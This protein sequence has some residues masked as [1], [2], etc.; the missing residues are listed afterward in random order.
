MTANNANQEQPQAAGNAHPT[1]AAKK[2]MAV[3]GSIATILGVVVAL[4]TIWQYCS[5]P[6][7]V[8]NNIVL[9]VDSSTAMQEPMNEE[10][11]RL[12]AARSAFEQVIYT[13]SDQDNLALR[14]F[15]GACK[16]EDNTRMLVD[17]GQG[18][19]QRIADAVGAIQPRGQPTVIRG[20]AEAIG[21]F[22]DAAR[23][24]GT[25]KRIVAL[26]GGC[27]P[28]IAGF[29][30]QLNDTLAYRSD[31]A[32]RYHL[33]GLKLDEAC[34]RQLEQLDNIQLF[35]AVSQAQVTAAMKNA[36]A[37]EPFPQVAPVITTDL[38]DNRITV[39]EETSVKIIVQ[40]EDANG[41][42]VNLRVDEMPSGGQL[43]PAGSNRWRF[44]WTPGKGQAGAYDLT[45][46]AADGHGQSTAP[47]S[48]T[49]TPG[50]PANAP[51]RISLSSGD[52][53]VE[54]TVGKQLEM[55]IQAQD[56]PGDALSLEVVNPPDGSQFNV[57]SDT[58]G[59]FTWTPQASQ[60][61]RHDVGFSASDGE[62]QRTQTVAIVVAPAPIQTMSADSRVRFTF[63]RFYL[64][65][66]SKT[67]L[68]RRFKQIQERGDIIAI[69]LSG[70][71]CNIGTEAYNLGLSKKRAE[72]VKS[73][74]I[75]I[76]IA[77]DIISVDNKGEAAP[78][79]DNAS[80]EGRAENRRVE[81]KVSYNAN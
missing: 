64:D 73:Y 75:A 62:L 7:K 57:M 24:E 14:L 60:V 66:P 36:L 13:L 58:M 81:I 31:I 34:Q 69:V 50:G 59:R 18:N 43:T 40:A 77:P 16:A 28:C 65:Q 48:I 35:D 12:D 27:D 53:A 3:I 10:T 49:V 22:A 71:T 39:A 61:G 78:I 8:A 76:G 21:D 9:L 2:P 23:F 45:I 17:F 41:D 11:T 47:L 32:V 42:A 56:T 5:T 80:P 52:D 67:Y 4:L 20:I 29:A 74:L 54:A 26:I 33:I 68:D 46:T 6:S 79:A 19:K 44:D 25:S 1:P 30:G 70:H 51:P 15:G 37:G 55:T 63:D 38:A 72:A